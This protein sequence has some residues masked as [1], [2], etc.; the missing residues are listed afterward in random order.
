MSLIRSAR[1]SVY[2]CHADQSKPHS[3]CAG[4]SVE[5]EAA[6]QLA[7]LLLPC[8]VI[9]CVPSRRLTVGKLLLDSYEAGAGFP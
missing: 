4:E 7:I 9:T 1:S 8:P 6:G 3:G 2:L 5:D